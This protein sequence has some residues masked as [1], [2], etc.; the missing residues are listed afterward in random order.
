[1]S[2]LYGKTSGPK[3]LHINKSA[4]V[5]PLLPN[6]FVKP[7][8]L[9]FYTKEQIHQLLNMFFEIEQSYFEEPMGSDPYYTREEFDTLMLNY[10]VI[11]TPTAYTDPTNTTPY[12]T[13]A[14]INSRLFNYLEWQ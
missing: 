9:S 6:R 7:G 14:E 2:S 12:Y 4:G 11:E 8:G 1:M 13:I 5:F 10:L 3:N